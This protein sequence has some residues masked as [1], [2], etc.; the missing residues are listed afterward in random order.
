LIK[1][2]A[3]SKSFQSLKS[4]LP[5][6]LSDGLPSNELDLLYFQLF[7]SYSTA[8]LSG[9]FPSD[10]WNRLILQHSHYDT[11][12]KDA[13]IAIGALYKSIEVAQDSKIRL[14][15]KSAHL[16]H[17]ESAIRHYQKAL[18]SQRRTFEIGRP[19]LRTSLIS[20]LL[21][22]CFEALQGDHH[23]VVRQILCGVHLLQEYCPLS[24]GGH[25]SLSDQID[26]E[27]S[28]TFARLEVQLRTFDDGRPQR[29]QLPQLV[30]KLPSSCTK[31]SFS[32]IQKEKQRLRPIESLEEAR[33]S[34]DLLFPR[35]LDA[36]QRAEPYRY[37]TRK[38]VPLDI[39]M[40]VDRWTEELFS[41]GATFDTFFQKT[42]NDISGK[43]RAGAAAIKIGYHFAYIKI[44]ACFGLFE[45]VYDSFL[46]DFQEIVRLSK[47]LLQTK[48]PSLFQKAT[49][50]L[51]SVIGLPLFL[52]GMKCRDRILR[53]EAN[54]LL[55]SSKRREGMWDFEIGV[56]IIEWVISIEETGLGP[57]Q[58]VPECNRFRMLDITGDLR[59]RT[60]WVRC[61]QHTH[62]G[63]DF[64]NV[65]EM[66]FSF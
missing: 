58:V 27:I 43:N 7:Q 23:S 31:D 33:H 37:F 21:F 13:I 40:E 44:S 4:L 63:E 9:Y 57:H 52:T 38:N 3:T 54:A 15:T 64:I 20:C 34:W 22:I 59:T 60:G 62:E 28:Q 51:D 11:S 41:W 5:R 16:E 19:Q 47:Y 12:I 25:S 26:E 56:P 32:K 49:F 36:R 8:D 6:P 30:S 61:G 66:D 17:F 18:R 48:R 55:K 53:R 35:I 24:A 2:S 14:N 65:K 46:A 1:A 10:F 39:V 45:T 29:Y 50:M 42:W